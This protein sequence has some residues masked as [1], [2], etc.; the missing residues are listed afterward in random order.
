MSE[1]ENFLA[2]WS[3]RKRAGPVEEPAAKDPAEKKEELPAEQVSSAQMPR[4]DETPVFDLSR[5]PPIE[6]IV[7]GTDL[8]PFLAPGVPVELTRAALRRA[9]TTDP[10]IRDFIG[11]S[12]N[13]WDFT[14]AGPTGFGPL[15]PI[16]DVKK[17]L[18]EVFSHREESGSRGPE[19][20]SM[21]VAAG[22]PNPLEQKS[23]DV[24]KQIEN[25]VS[26]QGNMI[27][28]QVTADDSNENDALQNKS[29]SDEDSRPV[30]K[31]SHG[32]AL[33]E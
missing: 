9:W 3:R 28:Q 32:S 19:R 6:S 15:L 27:D 10:G 16:D 22:D 17:L 14:K 31:R 25:T 21:V 24:E 5:L 7:A 12:E 33:P 18:V 2:R 11:L 1:P 30:P 29:R 20:D 26:L 8:R 13:A 4:E 23:R